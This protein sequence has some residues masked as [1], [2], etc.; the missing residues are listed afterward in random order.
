MSCASPEA[1]ALINLH[2]ALGVDE[3][4]RKIYVRDVVTYRKP[5]TDQIRAFAQMPPRAEWITIDRHGAGAWRRFA[6][7]TSMIARTRA[8]HDGDLAPWIFPPSLTGVIYTS[9]TGPP[10]AT[11]TDQD[12]SDLK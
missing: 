8:F 6:A 7:E 5:M 3:G 9:A 1:R 10:E 12:F 4:F 11:M 2:A